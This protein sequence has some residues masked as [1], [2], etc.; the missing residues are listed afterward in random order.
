MTNTKL[1]PLDPLCECLLVLSE[2]HGRPSSREFL[3]SGLPLHDGLLSP[4]LFDRAANRNGLNSRFLQ[5]PLD[6]IQKALMPVVLLLEDGQACLLRGWSEGGSVANVILPELG[7]SVVNIP[8]TEL[9]G[10]YLG[11]MI[12]VRPQFRFDDRAPALSH[13]TKGNW[14]WSALKENLPL[15]RDVLVAAFLIN[16]FAL[17][18]PLFTMNVYDRVVPNQAV[19]TLWM[20]AAG[21]TVVIIFDLLL[22][23]MRGYFLDLAS[24]RI[25]IKLSSQIMERVLGMRM[26]ARPPSV[27]S[28]AAN[29]RS[30]ETIRDF[31]ASA[32]ITGIIDLP[33][34][35]IFLLVLAWISPWL[36]LPLMAGIAVVLLYSWTTQ[37]KLQLLTETAHRAGAMRNATLVESLV[38]L[39]TLKT[40]SSEGLMQSRWERSASFL[41]RIGVQL[42]LLA[43]SNS[44]VTQSVQQLVSVATIIL[45]VY[46]IIEGELSMGG[47]I[48]S[49]MLTGR[50]MAPLAQVSGLLAQ[51]HG[52]KTA[53]E[54]LNE[55]MEMPVERPAE[56]KFLTRKKFEGRIEFRDVS[57]TYPGADVA[58][59]KN[60]SFSLKAGEHVAIIGRVGS[61]KS[62][63]Q[64]LAMGLYQPTEGAVLIDGIDIRQLDPAELRQ[65]IGCVPQDVSL[66]Y[67]SLRENIVLSHPKASDE[68]VVHAAQIANLDGFVNAHPQGFDLPVGERGEVLSGGQ[69]KA[70]GIARGVIHEPPIMLM[71]EPTGSMDNAT[72]SVIKDKLQDFCASKTLLLVTHRNALLTLVDRIIVIDGGNVVAD[73]P[74]KEVVVALRE[75]RVGK[76]S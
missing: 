75:G 46:L 3:L 32:T 4:S 56:S 41:A 28:F 2:H 68:C 8:L 34:T 10:K 54:S 16:L 20:L 23:S 5:R 11:A 57:F 37:K 27:G 12:A 52:A 60:V 74:Q 36:T 64:K 59:L 67:G 39:E 19:E 69:R 49:S 1:D 71:D 38:G 61:G 44:H 70:V 7:N 29:L 51:F 21:V 26:E 24:K 22:K 62:T 30:Y 31:L 66:L 13:S 55:L 63:I 35:L 72:E 47:L 17:A 42:R 14:L 33:F 15:Y 9:Q 76:N 45:G 53:Y 43:A 50:A 6:K 65:H 73:G 58:A 40:T 18:L 25:D 48:A